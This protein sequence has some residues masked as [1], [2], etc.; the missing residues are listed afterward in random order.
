M[1]VPSEIKGK[2]RVRDFAICMDYIQGKR[3]EEIVASRKLEISARRVEQ[4]V[5]ANSAFVN[6]RVAWP[7]SKRIHELQRMIENA[8]ET[9]KDKADL[10]D[11]LRKEVEGDRPLIDNSTHNHL[12]LISQLHER[13]QEEPNI[14]VA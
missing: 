6:P 7:K 10:L 4:I 12:T 3:P 8:G 11:Q 2:N 1:K 13:S 14:T 5:Y 9:K